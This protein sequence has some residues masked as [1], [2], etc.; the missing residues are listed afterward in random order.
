M[1]KT[2]FTIFLASDDS[3]VLDGATKRVLGLGSDQ[4]E[5]NVT[6]T[7]VT[8]D[9]ADGRRIQN[10]KLTVVSTDDKIL[11]K[12]AKL[13]LQKNVKVTLRSA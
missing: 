10:R 6:V 3:E 8:K 9:E 7:P 5:V 12:A 11:N 4:T 13:D 2:Q 1:T